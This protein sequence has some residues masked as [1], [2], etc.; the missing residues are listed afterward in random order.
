MKPNER[1]PLNKHERPS[2]EPVLGDCK[3]TVL[4]HGRGPA[5]SV[6]IKSSMKTRL[7]VSGD[8]M[9]IKTE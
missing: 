5:Q 1:W 4:Q 3:N 9:Q 6:E 8:Y 7:F 2:L